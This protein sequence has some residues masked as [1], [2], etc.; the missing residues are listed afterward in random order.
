MQQNLNITLS[1][2]PDILDK[3]LR[4]DRIAY[5]EKAGLLFY[6]ATYTIHNKEDLLTVLKNQRNLA[7]IELAELKEVNPL[8]DE[9]AL[10][11]ARSR[12]IFLI[13]PREDSTTRVLFYN[14]YKITRPV[15]AEFKQLWATTSVPSDDVEL[16][17]AIE[18]A[19]MK[20]HNKTFTSTTLLT[21]SLAASTIAA[22]KQR[23]K[24]AK[25]PFRRIKITNDYLEGIDL[26]L[27][28]ADL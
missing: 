1:S 9:M 27:D 10:E 17:V 15:D 23:K 16:R 12:D 18:R 3:I 11:L 25:R 28:P 7:G 13:R 14:D 8:V 22:E 26:N 4:N 5:D 19:G 20:A 6:Q 24:A 2:H 21:S